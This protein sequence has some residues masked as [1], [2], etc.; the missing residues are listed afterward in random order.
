MEDKESSRWHRRQGWPSANDAF[1]KHVTYTDATVVGQSSRWHATLLR[2]G[3]SRTACPIYSTGGLHTQILSETESSNGAAE[4]H[5][6]QPP[7]GNCCPHRNGG[8]GHSDPGHRGRH[9]RGR[10]DP[11]T[12]AA[13]TRRCTRMTNGLLATDNSIARWL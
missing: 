11:A 4:P 10:F 8:G 2:H 3:C 7:L 9:W 12:E 6:R 13:W 5:Q 1:N